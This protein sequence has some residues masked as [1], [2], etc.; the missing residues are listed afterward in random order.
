MFN[1]ILAQFSEIESVICITFLKKNSHKHNTLKWIGICWNISRWK[2]HWSI[3]SWNR[4]LETVTDNMV[5]KY[6]F[7]LSASKSF[8]LQ[9]YA[10]YIWCN[11]FNPVS[12]SIY[13]FFYFLW[14][15]KH[16]KCLFRVTN[17]FMYFI[18]SSVV[19]HAV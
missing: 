4:M 17:T 19:I 10:K 14:F 13:I 7:A 2:Y 8:L 5:M 16:W 6:V 1:N 9:F 12:S 18:F 15:N 3:W 11:H